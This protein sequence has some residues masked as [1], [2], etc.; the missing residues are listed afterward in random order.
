MAPFLIVV[1]L[2]TI[3]FIFGGIVKGFATDYNIL[4]T[5]LDYDKAIELCSKNDG[6]G[7]MEFRINEEYSYMR[8]VE[9]HDGARFKLTR[10]KTII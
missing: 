5:T 8:L 4:T 6:V 1:G 9:C 3:T 2:C 10:D 7:T